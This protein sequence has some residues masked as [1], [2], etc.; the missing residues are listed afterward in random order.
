MRKLQ[1]DLIKLKSLYETD[2]SL[3]DIAKSM[4]ISLVSL[5]N[6]IKELGWKRQRKSL[7]IKLNIKKIEELQRIG[8]TTEQ[9]LQKLKI[10]RTTLIKFEKENGLYIED[11]IRKKAYL[12]SRKTL[13]EK[14]SKGLKAEVRHS[15]SYLDPYKDDIQSLLLKGVSKSNIAKQYN[16]CQST[17]YNFILLHELKAP[18]IKKLDDKKEKITKLFNQGKSIT[19]IAKRLDCSDVLIEREIKKLNLNRTVQEIKFNC[20]LGKKEELIKKMFLAGVSGQEIA[21]KVKAHPVSVYRIIK[22]LK[23]IKNKEWENCKNNHDFENKLLEMKEKGMSFQQIGEYFGVS[24]ATVF[25]QF[26]KLEKKQKRP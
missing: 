16:V 20:R 25:Y 17:I 10:S 15:W 2:I 8:L 11:P 9:I 23:L 13:Q 4:G 6:K 22:R 26:N 12:T 18:L 14:K 7:K 19:Y 24:P 1:I 21:R 3:A 5:R